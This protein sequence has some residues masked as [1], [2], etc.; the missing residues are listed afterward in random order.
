MVRSLV[1]E[2]AS[3]KP[4][5]VARCDFNRIRSCAT[6]TLL[7]TPLPRTHENVAKCAGGTGDQIS[8]LASEGD[9]SAVV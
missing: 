8:R 9:Q 5:V 7:K 3:G 1:L 6:I 2:E 4:V